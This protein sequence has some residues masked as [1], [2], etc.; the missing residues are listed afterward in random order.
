MPERVPGRDDTAFEVDGELAADPLVEPM[1]EPVSVEEQPARL[2]AKASAR[3]SLVMAD[4]CVNAAG[5]RRTSASRVEASELLV[6]RSALGACRSRSCPP[7]G[8]R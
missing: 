7:V 3:R 6:C 8:P 5:R 2:A 1:A 4:S